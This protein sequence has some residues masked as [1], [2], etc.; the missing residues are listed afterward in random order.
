MWR[1]IYYSEGLVNSQQIEE[2]HLDN[3]ED[4]EMVG[5]VVEYMLVYC[6]ATPQIKMI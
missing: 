1:I 4:K 3:E 6:N 2:K 5:E